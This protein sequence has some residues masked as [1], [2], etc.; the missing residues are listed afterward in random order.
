MG[1]SLGNDI[2]IKGIPGTLTSGD[3]GWLTTNEIV[4]SAFKKDNHTLQVIPF[5]GIGE[6]MTTR[7]KSFSQDVV[8]S[9][10][11]SCRYIKKSWSTELGWFS[12]LETHDNSGKWNKSLLG[13]GLYTQVKF[14]F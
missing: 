5:I 6:V 4:F 8:G 14:R 7:G 3:S 1:F 13:D 9:M 10:G 11:I 2:G 12:P